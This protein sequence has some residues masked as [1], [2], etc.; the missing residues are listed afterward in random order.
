MNQTLS[1]MVS[2]AKSFCVSAGKKIK[3]VVMDPHFVAVML[4]LVVSRRCTEY[5]L[6]CT[7]NR[8]GDRCAEEVHPCRNEAVLRHSRY[9]CRSWYHLRLHQ[10]EQRGAGC[11]EEH[12]DDCRCLHLP[13][14][15]SPGIATVLRTLRRRIWQQSK[16][17]IPITRYSRD[18]KSPLNSWA[19]E[20][21]TLYGQL[22]P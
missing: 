22:L 8:Q 4:L 21:D 15:G 9:R 3:G 11:Q 17:T 1:V 19:F 20:G 7:S 18:F 2:G 10:D 16:A 12:H 14:G 6:R 5:G 13:R